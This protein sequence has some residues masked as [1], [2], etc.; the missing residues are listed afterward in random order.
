MC[1]F[2]RPFLTVLPRHS[3]TAAN[4]AVPAAAFLPPYFPLRRSLLFHLSAWLMQ[5]Q[6]VEAQHSEN[7]SDFFS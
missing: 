1:D 7:C 3:F 2:S 5:Q 6:A 4:A